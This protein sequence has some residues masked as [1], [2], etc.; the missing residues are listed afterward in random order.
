LSKESVCKW[1]LS[2]AAGMVFGVDCNEN[3]FVDEINLSENQLTGKI[4]SEIGFLTSL[5]LLDLS[6]FLYEYIRKWILSLI[7]SLYIVLRQ[8]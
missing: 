8:V 4:P 5:T 3:G 6:K 1:N 2:N 7:S